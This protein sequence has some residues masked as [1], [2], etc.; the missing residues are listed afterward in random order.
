MSDMITYYKLTKIA[1]FVCTEDDAWEEILQDLPHETIVA[2]DRV[3]H[4]ENAPASQ[5]TE[6]EGA[7]LAIQLL[8]DEAG[9]DILCATATPCPK[10]EWDTQWEEFV[11]F[12]DA[13]CVS[14]PSA[15]AD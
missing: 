6:E 4:F 10:A 7:A 12:G 13:F 9:W 15:R 1:W 11:R 3:R 14:H 2:I 5:L 8:S